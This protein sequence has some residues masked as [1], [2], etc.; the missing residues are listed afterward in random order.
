MHRSAFDRKFYD[1]NRRINILKV[2][3]F[4]ALQDFPGN[5]REHGKL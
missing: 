2:E 1:Y 4:R 3:A 5:T